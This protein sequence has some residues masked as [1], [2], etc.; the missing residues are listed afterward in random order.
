MLYMKS[1][2][3]FKENI[4]LNRWGLINYI[5]IDSTVWFTALKLY[6]YC[7][8]S[9]KYFSLLKKIHTL[10]ES[11]SKLMSTSSHIKAEQACTYAPNYH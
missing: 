1:N 8:C 11:F 6:N 2:L 5:P 10:M 3:A 9:Q 4:F 7:F